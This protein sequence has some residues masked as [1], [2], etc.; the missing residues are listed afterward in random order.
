MANRSYLYALSN[1]PAS[2]TD[3]PE[4]IQGLSEWPYAVPLVYYILLS[5]EPQLSAS[6]ITN[7]E[8]DASEPD[9][10]AIP[11]RYYALTGNFEAGFKRFRR[12]ATVVRNAVG[13]RAA[14]L[15]EALSV[16][17]EFLSAHQD[18][19]FLLETLELDCMEEGWEGD[20]QRQLASL[21]LERA[22]AAGAAVDALSRFDLIAAA[23]LLGAAQAGKRA[24][25][26]F[27]GLALSNEFDSDP[28][29][30]MGMGYWDEILYYEL[31]NR[32]DFEAAQSGQQ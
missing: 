32:K 27:R 13:K 1:Q 10:P 9:K 19:Y 12:F 28:D 7:A 18:R 15:T 17:T 4:T 3:R 31:W 16:A 23:Q 30:P 22:R 8:E 25:A 6:L 2:F 21:H 11:T 14:G 29:H 5:G 24:R 26:P 20:G